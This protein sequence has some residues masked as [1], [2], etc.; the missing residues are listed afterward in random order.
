MRGILCGSQ[1]T[2]PRLES[3]QL[4]ARFSLLS[5]SATIGRSGRATDPIA[6]FSLPLLRISQLLS[7]DPPQSPFDVFFFFLSFLHFSS[8]TNR[9]NLSF[10]RRHNYHSLQILFRNKRVCLRFDFEIYFIGCAVSFVM[11]IWSVWGI[12]GVCLLEC[13]RSINIHWN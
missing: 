2:C 3:N 13:Y 5:Y 12:V 1:V 7:F 9:F 11:K 6:V 10:Q 8:L 4:P